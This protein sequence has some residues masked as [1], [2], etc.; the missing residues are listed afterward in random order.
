MKP[1]AASSLRQRHRP[2]CALL[3]ALSA[4]TALACD[5]KP[6]TPGSSTQATA[7]PAASASAAPKPVAPKVPD[8]LVD[9]GGAYI[10]GE[11]VDFKAPDAAKKLTAIMEKHAAVL[12]G[13]DVTLTALRAAKTPDVVRTVSALAEKAKG[14]HVKTQNRDKK[15]A[16]ISV[17]PD[18][19]AGK[20]ADCTV[21]MMVLKDRATASWHIRGGVATKYPKGMAGPDMSQTAEGVAKQWKSCPAG[22]ALVLAGDDTVEWGLVF[23][24]T[25]MAD[26]RT[27]PEAERVFVLPRTA[28][29]AGRAVKIGDLTPD[30]VGGDAPRDTTSALEGAS[31]IGVPERCR[32]IGRAMAKKKTGK[33]IPKDRPSQSEPAEQTDIVESTPTHSEPAGADA[34]ADSN[35]TPSPRSVRPAAPEVPE[36]R[37]T[38]G[39]GPTVTV[40]GSAPSTPPTPS[41]PS[42][43]PPPTEEVAPP[44]ATKPIEAEGS[45]EK[46]EKTNAAAAKAGAEPSAASETNE[47]EGANPAEAAKAAESPPPKESVDAKS[48]D[49]KSADAKSAD[50]KSADAKSADARPAATDSLPSSV[51]PSAAGKDKETDKLDGRSL[52]DENLAPKSSRAPET[53][54]KKKKKKKK[55]DSDRSSEL[56]AETTKKSEK[57]ATSEP[58]IATAAESEPPDSPRGVT[59]DAGEEVHE[60][61]FSLSDEKVAAAHYAPEFQDEEE[62]K[63]RPLTATEIERR[64]RLR[65]IVIIVVGTA[66]AACLMIGVQLS[67]GGNK[68]A[69]PPPLDPSQVVMPA[70]PTPKPTPEVSAEPEAAPAVTAGAVAS[71]E[72]GA[73]SASASASAAVPEAAP[74]ASAAAPDPSASAAPSGPVDAEEAKKLA[75]VALRTLES[76]NNKGAVEKSSAAVDADPTDAAPYLYW[77]TAL[78]NMGK[79]ADAKKVFQTCVDKATHG[80]KNDC[81]QFR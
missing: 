68:H 55:T 10:G 75:K 14:L 77:G 73:A 7:T 15:D 57:S 78:M 35:D 20:L 12:A 9:E 32:R 30:V 36:A 25:Q 23:D 24:L 59:L 63:I 61:F 5:D 19:K 79:M 11:R 4:C 21:T 13:K 74:S 71:A 62:A 70:A 58:K 81:R 33:K 1:T 22:T 37:T 29:I 45:A 52:L 80:P 3:L 69:D 34:G 66:A 27:T 42:T 41:T 18:D 38:L 67:M 50:A 17:V 65:R 60:D 6:A 56:P 39:S 48:A 49:A 47:S 51:A 16:T 40:T 46:V 72:L 53:V 44:S 64:H 54:T 26:P 31:G 28:P 43:P 2:L 76:G 8:V